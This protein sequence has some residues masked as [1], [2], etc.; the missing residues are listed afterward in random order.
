MDLNQRDSIQ[1]PIRYGTEMNSAYCMPGQV[2]SV[3]KDRAQEGWPLSA[4]PV[5]LL[6][7]TCAWP[8]TG[9][10]NIYQI[11]TWRVCLRSLCYFA[12]KPQKET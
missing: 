7:P 6:P 2:Q 4:I 5:S 3:S 10:V 12:L 8:Q 11:N 9:Q 1:S